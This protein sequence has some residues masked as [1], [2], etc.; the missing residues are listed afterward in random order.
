MNKHVLYK[1]KNQSG[2]PDTD[3]IIYLSLGLDQYKTG[4]FL[5]VISR[6]ANKFFHIGVNQTSILHPGTSDGPN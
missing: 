3:N 2:T 1:G 5:Q 4:L 6:C